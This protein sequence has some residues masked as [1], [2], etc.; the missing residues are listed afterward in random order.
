M[1]FQTLEGVD[2]I[3]QPLNLRISV[4]V[5]QN[6]NECIFIETLYELSFSVRGTVRTAESKS[7]WFTELTK[8]THMKNEDQFNS[9]VFCA[10]PE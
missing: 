9:D 4:S 7:L 3:A 10:V 2:V 5:R 1:V 8:Q 6:T